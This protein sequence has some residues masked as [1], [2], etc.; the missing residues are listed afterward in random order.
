MEFDLQPRIADVLPEE[1][2]DIAANL[3]NTNWVWL[4]LA[5]AYFKNRQYLH[6]MG[7]LFVFAFKNPKALGPLFK[8]VCRKISR[9]AK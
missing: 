8:K 3:R 1:Y 6:M 4:P 2:A 9:K 5:N 7:A